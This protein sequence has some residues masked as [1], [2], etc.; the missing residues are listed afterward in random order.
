[1]WF[2][3]YIHFTE[4][5]S[6]ARKTF[7]ISLIRIGVMMS[8]ASHDLSP[9]PAMP[10]ADTGISLAQFETLNVIDKRCRNITRHQTLGAPGFG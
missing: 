4:A 1:M 9:M 5:V 3:F 8:T 6:S 10:A 2:P 7:Q